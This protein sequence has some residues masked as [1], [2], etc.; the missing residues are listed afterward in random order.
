M[1]FL[2]AQR[3]E[4]RTNKFQESCNFGARFNLRFM[5]CRSKTRKCFFFFLFFVQL[6]ITYSHTPVCLGKGGISGVIGSQAALH[7]HDSGGAS[8]SSSCGQ[9]RGKKD[10]GPVFNSLLPGAWATNRSLTFDFFLKNQLLSER[11]FMDQ[12]IVWVD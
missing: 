3:V 10:P 1:F 11:F 2:R 9:E 5:Y 6:P 7:C 12:N 4:P 8:S